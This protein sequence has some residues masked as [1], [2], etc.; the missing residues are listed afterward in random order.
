MGWASWNG[1]GEK[2]DWFWEG[3]LEAEKKTHLIEDEVKHVDSENS[4]EWKP[5]FVAS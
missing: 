1:K 5:G 3:I 4:L 2:T